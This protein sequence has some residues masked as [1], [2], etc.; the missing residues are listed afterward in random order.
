[1]AATNYQGKKEKCT[2]CS[3]PKTHQTTEPCAIA[4][5]KCKCL[6]KKCMRWLTVAKVPDMIGLLFIAYMSK[7]SETGEKY[8][9]LV[10]HGNKNSKRHVIRILG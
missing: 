2:R 1:M 7:I 3:T 8:V 9:I 10:F 6:K 5:C 4:A